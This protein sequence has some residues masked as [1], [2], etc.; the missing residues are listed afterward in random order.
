MAQ[1]T[2]QTKYCTIYI[3]RHGESK[4]NLTGTLQG[5]KDSPLTETGIKQ[6]KAMAKKL[7]PIEFKAIFSSD[8]VRA[9]HTAEIIAL[10]KKI[11]IKTS[12][13]I[14]EGSMGKYE[15]K[16]YERFRKELK[17]LIEQRNQLAD[18]DKL[19]FRLDEGIETGEDIINRS[20]SFL[21]KIAADY[22]DK[23]IL[24]VTHGTVLRYLLVHLGYGTHEDLTLAVVDNTATIILKTDGKE[25][26]VDQT[27]GINLN[28]QNSRPE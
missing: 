1:L 19:R 3:V 2:A 7:K 22:L 25:F 28:K 21:K 15:G 24:M 14:R 20:V 26:I 6:A 11:T 8:L 16:K 23:T 5:H 4:W 12:Q 18:K 27:E 10:D 17:H 13:A 9:K